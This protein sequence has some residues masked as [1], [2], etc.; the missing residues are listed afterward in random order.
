MTF[1]ARPDRPQ[2][3]SLRRVL[4][5]DIER[6]KA[7]P[8]LDIAGMALDKIGASAYYPLSHPPHIIRGG[9]GFGVR[10]LVSLA[11]NWK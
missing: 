5:R 2:F 9:T 3:I 11:Q 6:L 1:D 10:A 4:N 8:N 7:S